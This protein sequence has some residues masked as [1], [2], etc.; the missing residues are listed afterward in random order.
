[1]G[2][3]SIYSGHPLYK[4][5]P[6]TFPMDE[7]SNFD[8]FSELVKKNDMFSGDEAVEHLKKIYNFTT[9]TNVL[10]IG[11]GKPIADEAMVNTFKDEYTNLVNR[12]L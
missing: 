1:M 8:Q 3:P 7:I 11:S 4:G 2:L 5:L 10:G 12:F 9:I 6:G